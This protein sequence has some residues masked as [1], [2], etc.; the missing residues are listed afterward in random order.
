MHVELYA[1]GALRQPFSQSPVNIVLPAFSDEKKVEGF[2]ELVAHPN[3]TIEILLARD[4]EIQRPEDRSNRR[5]YDGQNKWIQQ[6]PDFLGPRLIGYARVLAASDSL[7]EEHP[8][9]GRW[10]CKKGK[11]ISGW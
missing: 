7:F 1:D 9:A 10:L 4:E 5:R 8:F 2:P 3:F 6:T 11:R